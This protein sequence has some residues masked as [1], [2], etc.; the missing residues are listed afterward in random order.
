VVRVIEC[1]K[2]HYEVQDQEMG[3]VYRWCP[4]S[5][6]LDCDCGE[7]L[8]LTASTTA[9]V[10]CG[11]DHAGFI[12]EVLEVRAVDKVEHPWRLVRPYYRPTRGT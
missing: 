2:A 6:V 7:E 10:G 11:A 9:C 4:E 8:S 3:K 1:V 5:A 12:G